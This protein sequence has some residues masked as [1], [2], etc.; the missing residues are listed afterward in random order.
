MTQITT[1]TRGSTGDA[2]TDAFF[3][4]DD[5]QRLASVPFGGRGTIDRRSSWEHRLAVERG[6]RRV[7]LAGVRP[8]VVHLRMADVGTLAA[9]RVARQLGIPVVFTAAPDPHVVL[10]QLDPARVSRCQLRGSR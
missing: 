6:V 4:C 8:D 2:I 7:F 3:G 5:K 9:G 1:L 10:G